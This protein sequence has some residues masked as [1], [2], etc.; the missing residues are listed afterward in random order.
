M[1]GQSVVPGQAS[2]RQFTSTFCHEM[3]TALLES[4]EE[5]LYLR[6]QKRKHRQWKDAVRDSFLYIK[7]PVW[8]SLGFSLLSLSVKHQEETKPLFHCIRPLNW[9]FNTCT[10]ISGNSSLEWQWKNVFFSVFTIILFLF[11]PVYKYSPIKIK[12]YVNNL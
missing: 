4:G 9:P 5:A 8:N 2:Q 11:F 12:F 3:T 1:S 10:C 6:R 7:I